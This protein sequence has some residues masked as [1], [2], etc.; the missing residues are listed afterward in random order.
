MGL[1]TPVLTEL[2]GGDTALSTTALVV[3]GVGSVGIIPAV[4]VLLFG[5]IAVP[6]MPIIEQLIVAVV[7]PML[8]AVDVRAWQPERVGAYDAYYPAISATMVILIIDGVTAA[9][10]AIIRSNVSLSAGIRVGVVVLNTLG[11]GIG[12][13]TTRS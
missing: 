2:A 13:E 10:A 11:Y 7:A 4:A 1:V 9:N 12:P 5:E 3:I 6:T 8:V